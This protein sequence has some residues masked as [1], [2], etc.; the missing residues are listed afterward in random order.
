MTDLDRTGT[1]A[2]VTGSGNGIGLEAAKAFQA[3]GAM[4][5]G[6]DLDVTALEGVDG[7]IPVVADVT[8]DDQMA[9]LVRIAN[10]TGDVGVVMANAGIASGGRIENVPIAEWTR[11][12]DVNVVGVV[13]TI[14]PFLTA[15]RA[16]GSGHL[17]ITG[18][19]AGLFADP[20]GGNASYATT[21]AALL[22]FTR[23]L[24][25]QVAADGV[26]VHYLAPRLTDT[27]FPTSAVAWGRSGPRVMSDRPVEGADTIET[28]IDALLEGMA[29]RRLLISLTP[30]TEE[31]LTAFAR[32]SR[33]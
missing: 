4:V 21:K 12:L 32:S 14:Q 17:V 20:G 13:R 3:R 33:P 9:D 16:R 29:A 22:G 19:S 25:E 23:A 24:A 5:V 11:L 28:V 8:D 18:S 30:D 6:A 2:V 15:M 27:A 26:A 10:D 1:V 31:R 7:I